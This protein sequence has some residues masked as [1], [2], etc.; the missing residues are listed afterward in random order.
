MLM[1]QILAIT[2]LC[3]YTFVVRNGPSAHWGKSFYSEV[4]TSITALQS[5]RICLGSH[6]SQESDFIRK[7][8]QA[9]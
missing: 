3:G 7:C 2:K 8:N 1:Y 5:E 9:K 4:V 6:L